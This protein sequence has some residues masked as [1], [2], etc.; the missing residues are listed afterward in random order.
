MKYISLDVE[1]NSLD[2]WETE[3][4]SWAVT[5]DDYVNDC[6]L[7]E[8]PEN[9]ETHRE[10][11]ERLQ[12]TNNESD[13]IVGANFKF[14]Y[15]ILKRYGIDFKDV[16][17]IDV[18]IIEY[19]LS[20]Q[21]KKGISLEGLAGQYLG[22]SKEDI[23]FKEFRADEYPADMLLKYNTKDT[24]LTLDIFNKQ[25]ETVRFK[26]VFGERFGEK[27]GEECDYSLLRL[28]SALT[29]MLGD[30]ELEGCKIDTNSLV[31]FRGQYEEL[32]K[33]YENRINQLFEFPI[34]INSPVQLSAALFG[35]SFKDDGVETVQ[36]TLKS[37]EVKEYTR[38]CKV[39]K[40][41]QGL[42]FKPS[43]TTN[44]GEPSTSEEALKM[45]KTKTKK[46]ILFKELFFKYK[47]ASTV[48]N[49][50]LTKY[51]KFITKDNKLYSNFNMVNTYTGRLSSSN[52]NVQ[53]IPRNSDGINL[54][55]LFISRYPNGYILELDFKQLE[56]RVAA[57][58]CG[59]ETMIR[60]IN[61]G[62]DAHKANAALAFNIKES[63][64][65]PEQRQS[66]KTVS[67][68]LIYGQTAYGMANYR[69]DI[70]VDDEREAQLIIDKVYEKYPKLAKWHSS[71]VAKVTNSYKLTIPSGRILY[72]PNPD[73]VTN[74][75][76]Y[77]VQAFSFDIAYFL[78]ACLYFKLS[79]V[80]DPAKYATFN[81]VHDC[82]LFDC[83]DY[84]TAKKITSFSL[85]FIKNNAYTYVYKFFNYELK[86]PLE[87]EA[88]VGKT[89]GS[90]EEI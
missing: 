49:K 3:L 87:L 75:K 2:Y 58:L 45:L 61:E 85:D 57:T 43:L 15:Q 14:D 66:A 37:G 77:P 73:K 68:G 38:K 6:G 46:Q 50:Y 80:V 1:T 63:E 32:I 70:P 64:V 88:E 41:M 84:E 69:P 82:M 81:T 39:D 89:W 27:F 11:L 53:Q 55:D 23:D 36:K 24:E 76:N 86:V 34:N 51:E 48:Y 52:P 19:L 72:F 18:I 29:R 12:R 67:F 65:T 33:D 4:V 28:Y 21:S 79:K 56:W 35:G 42:G 30:I 74:I 22:D 40:S 10:S 17:I 31:S 90:V 47:K 9:D 7:V 59:D 26:N 13:C 83:K 60:E 20:M 78:F 5:H 16:F 71:L 44:S 8:H 54:R 62:V 25:I